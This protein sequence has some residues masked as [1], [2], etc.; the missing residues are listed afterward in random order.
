MKSKILLND[1]YSF[2]G[3]NVLS[4]IQDSSTPN[5]DLLIRESVQNSC[6]AFDED[7]SFVRMNFIVN[8]FN[9]L[10]F[11]NLFNNIEEF[12]INLNGD[13]YD[14]LAICDTNT[15][16]LLGDHLKN[17]D[18]P[19]N[20]YKLVYDIMNKKNGNGT[21]GGSWGIGKSVYFRFGVGFCVYYSRTFEN[22]KYINKLAIVYIEDETKENTMIKLKDNRGIALFGDL[23]EDNHA[24]PIYDD[25][26]ISKVLNIFGI[27]LYKGNTTGTVVIIPYLNMEK[28][29]SRV[30]EENCYWNLDFDKKLEVALQRWYFPRLNNTKYNGRYLVAAVNDEK[31]E[32]NP[33][34]NVM[35]KMYNGDYETCESYKIVSRSPQLY[36]GQLFVK[37]FNKEELFMNPPYNMPSPYCMFDINEEDFIA[38]PIVAY[39]RKPGMIITYDKSDW[40]NVPLSDDEFLIGIFKLNDECE[41]NSEQLGEYV[42]GTEKANHKNWEDAVVE[43]YPNFTDKRPIRRIFG[44]IKNILSDNYGDNK[45]Q[46]IE[47]SNSKLKKKLGKLL[48]PPQGFGTGTS[49]DPKHGNTGGSIKVSKRNKTKITFNGFEDGMLSFETSAYLEPS[50]AVKFDFFIKSGNKKY[51]FLEWNAM[52][53]KLPCELH[54]IRVSQIRIGKLSLNSTKTF[55][56]N[57]DLN[58]GT[59]KESIKFVFKKNEITDYYGVT[60]KNVNKEDNDVSIN[61]VILVKPIDLTYSLNVEAE[62]IPSKKDGVK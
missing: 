8:K 9:N 20:L 14:Y 25:D 54:S 47:S 19:Q 43:N 53:F 34:F 7:K 5:I 51:S 57:K 38:K 61:F 36:F 46:E 28:F 56:F 44:E 12:S 11:K 18:K 16:G 62:L 35:Q 3:A 42:R 27:E 30:N 15:T 49:I 37:K 33:Y 21:S 39:T 60:I 22:N 29:E 41:Y 31:V 2:T 55:M 6:D 13:N 45:V 4:Q 10:S 52:G 23:D 58:S 59:L 48:L 17:N 50:D 24:M 32:L 1:A 26:Y 40:N